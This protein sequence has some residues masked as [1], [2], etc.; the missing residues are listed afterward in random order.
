VR[1]LKWHPGQLLPLPHNQVKLINSPKRLSDLV[2][3]STLFNCLLLFMI[4]WLDLKCG[5]HAAAG[6][7]WSKKKVGL[8]LSP[9]TAT[10]RTQ[11]NFTRGKPGSYEP[12]AKPGNGCALSATTFNCSID[13]GVKVARA[14]V[15]LGLGQLFFP[16]A[17]TAVA[18]NR[19]ILL[20]D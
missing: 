11:A 18:A 20:G 2:P 3:N 19:N 13:S 17:S 8:A 12:T 15:Y 6:N 14:A 1:G 16:S 9:S 5:A 7:Y 10:V 4:S